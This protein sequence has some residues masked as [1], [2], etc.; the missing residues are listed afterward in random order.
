[1]LSRWSLSLWDDDDL[2]TFRIVVAPPF[3]DK[4]TLFYSEDGVSRSSKTSLAVYPKTRRHVP[5][6]N[7]NFALYDI[8]FL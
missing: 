8:L 4:I 6:E 3:Q 2:S 1:M 7:E 5:D